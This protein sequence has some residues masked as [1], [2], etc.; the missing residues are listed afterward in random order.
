[1]L[2]RPITQASCRSSQCQKTRPPNGRDPVSPGSAYLEH[3]E[4]TRAEIGR[5][6]KVDS[7]C[8]PRTFRIAGYVQMTRLRLPALS[9]GR[10]AR[11]SPSG[12]E[13]AIHRTKSR[14]LNT[15][16]RSQGS[17]ASRQSP[18]ARPRT[19]FR[20]ADASPHASGEG[21]FSYS[22]PLF[23]AQATPAASLRG[24]A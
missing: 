11:R 16:S 8:R 24:G 13:P 17:A 12:T 18:C 21:R 1:M 7:R 14:K 5:S 15:P 6:T 3:K 9:R 2:S 22:P 10:G 20:S 23:A 19:A 4:N